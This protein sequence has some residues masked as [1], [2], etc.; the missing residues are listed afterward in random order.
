[1]YFNLVPTTPLIF[2]DGNFS[3][4]LFEDVRKAIRLRNYFANNTRSC[5]RCRHDFKQ[6]ETR[7]PLTMPCLRHSSATPVNKTM[8]GKKVITPERTILNQ[9]EQKNERYF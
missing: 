2:I 4:G 1:M 7:K 9:G 5:L 8:P 3:A 6:V